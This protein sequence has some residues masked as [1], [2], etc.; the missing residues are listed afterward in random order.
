MNKLNLLVYPVISV[1]ALAAAFAARAE[2]PTLDNSAAQ[3]W[4]QAKTRAQVQAELV[5]A[6]ADGSMK[7]HSISYNPM[8]TAKTTLTREEVRAQARVDRS[9]NPQAQFYGEDSGSLYL[10]QLPL[11]P[12]ASRT[13]AG[14]PV[15]TA[16]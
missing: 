8:L 4:S 7:F 1:L 6:R 10:S 3:V 9:I 16:R 2:S 12:E 11:A 13:L 14:A 5:Q 15:K